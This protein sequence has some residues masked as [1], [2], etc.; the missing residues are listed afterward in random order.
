MPDIVVFAPHPD[1]DILGCGGTIAHY[2]AMGRTVNIV[3]LTSGEAGSLSLPQETLSFTREKE[4]REA[5]GILGVSDTRF[6]RWP[7]GYLEMKPDYLAAL[8]GLIRELRPDIVLIPHAGD[9]VPDHQTT[10][11]LVLEAARRASGPW[12]PDC[13]GKPWSV[14][15]ILGYEV[16]TPL[17][18][19]TTVVD[20]SNYAALK[21]QAIQCHE[22][23][24]AD[25]RYDEGMMGLNRY[26]GV[27]T[28]LGQYCECFQIIRDFNKGNQNRE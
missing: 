24:V 23:Q 13:G 6:M 19:P 25:I 2:I 17:S 8:T 15:R 26:R 11:H 10:H 3:Y 18:S 16:W 4:A 5:A 22:S 21:L 12:F 7:D 28:G 14:S 1:D 27:I 20:I 9:A